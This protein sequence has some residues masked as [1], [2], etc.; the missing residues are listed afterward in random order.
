MPAFAAAYTPPGGAAGMPGMGL[1][2]GAGSGRGFLVRGFGSA[3]AVGTADAVVGLVEFFGA[4]DG[5]PVQ[6][7]SSTLISVAARGSAARLT[8]VL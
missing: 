7:A 5:D 3:E 4:S 8:A 1:W 6:P 2:K